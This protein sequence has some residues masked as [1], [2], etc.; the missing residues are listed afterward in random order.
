MLVLSRTIN[1]TLVIDNNIRITV[2]S[3]IAGRVKLLIEAPQDVKVQ[4]QEVYVPVSQL[5]SE[6][7]T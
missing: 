5:D 7:K 3:I 6:S 1:E 4:R 2:G